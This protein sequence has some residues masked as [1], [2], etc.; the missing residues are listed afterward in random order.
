MIADSRTRDGRR[1]GEEGTVIVMTALLMVVLFLA[2]GFAIDVSRVYAVRADLQN[3]ADAAALAAAR[4]LNSGSGGINDA[5]TRA[6]AIANSY[7]PERSP[8]TVANVEFAINHDGPYVNQATAAGSP[9]NI[10]FVRVTTQAANVPILFAVKALGNSHAETGQAV[11][12]MSVGLT[13]IC[14]FF[15]IAVALTDINPAP[16]T[17]ML[18]NFTN[19]SGNSATLAD[20]NYIILEVPDITGNG[21]PETAVLSAGLTGICKSINEDINFNMTPSAN[22]NNGPNQ[23]KD[24]TDTRFDFQPNGYG[25]ALKDTTTF[26]PDSNVRQNI[27]FDQYINRTAV[28]APPNHPP[29]QDDRRILLVPIIAPGTYSPPK[30]KIVKWGAFFI[31]RRIVNT[32]PCS[33]SG[34]CG[35]LEVEWIDERL[36]I[37]R[38]TA[39]SSGSSSGLTVA[40]L[41][42]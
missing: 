41:Y 3:A 25:N 33:V 17:T 15:P 22:Q 30:T 40:V 23:I 26:P 7:G 32:N 1:R 34:N 10:R 21:A 39:S 8:I 36:V 11:A 18:L 2:L 9:A 5:V 31:K 4:E 14:D 12:G 19:G 27:T 38:G 42:K 29:G 16:N 24:G 28:T 35:V 13:G 37:G 20:K 6:N